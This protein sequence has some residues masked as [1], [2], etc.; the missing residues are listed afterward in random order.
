MMQVVPK[1]KVTVSITNGSPLAFYVSEAHLANVLRTVST[2][3]FVGEVTAI[4]IALLRQM[5]AQ[6]G[7]SLG[8]TTITGEVSA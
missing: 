5:G 6:V 8:G 3:E 7:G 1:W 2:I 4:S